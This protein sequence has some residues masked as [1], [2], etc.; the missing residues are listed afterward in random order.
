MAFVAKLCYI[1]ILDW[2][3]DDSDYMAAMIE[4]TKDWIKEAKRLKLL[5]SRINELGRINLIYV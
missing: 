5:R 1:E 4:E 3:F 2:P